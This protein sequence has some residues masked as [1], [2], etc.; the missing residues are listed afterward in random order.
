MNF[1]TEIL[2][3]KDIGGVTI[4]EK[5][6]LVYS[7]K[8]ALYLC[9][10]FV[11]ASKLKYALSSLDKKAEIIACGREV[12]DERDPNLFPF[13]SAV[14]KFLR[15][16][17]DYLIFLPSSM[18]T[19]FDMAFLKESFLVKK[20]EEYSFDAL[21]SSLVNYGY[22]RTDY[23]NIEGQFALRGDI[24]D[25]FLFGEDSP[26]RIEFFDEEVE[27]II[28]FDASSMKTIKE[29]DSVKISPLILKLGES[30]VTDIAENI[31]IDEPIKIENECSILKVMI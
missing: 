4:G 22:E 26:T 12:E 16:E 14:S 9:G 15:G 29:L 10:D 18:T 3:H 6:V 23:V 5:S 1:V 25:I 13:S 2:N 19:K 17:L 31:V 21:S 30:V 20:G 11:T 7:L 27:R 8:R 28:H 24:L